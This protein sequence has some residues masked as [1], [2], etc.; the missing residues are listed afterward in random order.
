[1]NEWDIHKITSILAMTL[2]V[3][4]FILGTSTSYTEER[5]W[6]QASEH[7][8]FSDRQIIV[9]W[10]NRYEKA[11]PPICNVID[12]VTTWTG[13]IGLA[14]VVVAGLTAF[15]IPQRYIKNKR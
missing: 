12:S 10:Y 15:S 7:L 3:A 2:L 14:C 1:M 5:A 11:L 8:S 9:H 6:E 13:F 4:T